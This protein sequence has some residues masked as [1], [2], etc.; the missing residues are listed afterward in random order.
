MIKKQDFYS[1][2]FEKNN[3]PVAYKSIAFKDQK[4]YTSQATSNNLKSTYSYTYVPDYITCAPKHK[5]KIKNI[6][7]KHGYAAN[8]S[9]YKTIDDYVKTAFK[10]SFRNNIK[11][12]LKRTE[13]CLNIDY[14]MYYGAIE[15]ENYNNLMQLF[16]K[17]LSKRFN[18]VNA[19][20]LTL[21]NW[22]FYEKNAYSLILQKKACLFVIY[23]N[24][25]PIAFS[26]SFVFDK[27]FYF[28]IP[29]FNLDY[30]KFTLGNVVIYKN[31]EWCI[32]HKFKLFDMGYGGFENKVNWCDTTYNF[33]HH[34]ISK[35]NNLRA[36]LHAFFLTYKYKLINFLIDKKV[37]IKIR[38][39]LNKLKKTPVQPIITFN[40]TS[41]DKTYSKNN[42]LA[43]DLDS[44]NYQYLKK[45]LNDFLYSNQEKIV[46]VSI[47]KIK[48][49]N[50]TYLIKGNKK[51]I[52]IKVVQ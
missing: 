22:D 35:Q 16:H 5:L 50:N 2:F 43:I 47:F 18:N 31:L 32:N 38:K 3:I 25:T 8:L 34:I 4:I 49:E 52:K 13:L 10:S 24:N 41:C 33:E 37:N 19:R 36:N 44:E 11:R 21:E 12:S 29:T 6:F 42:L 26:L 20:N 7:L 15:Q 14:K 30:S 40:I 23:N 17:M 27:I 1:S 46:D 45:P 28:A 48:E 51:Q 39:F 9:N